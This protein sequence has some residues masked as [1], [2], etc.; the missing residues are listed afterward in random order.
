MEY[1]RNSNPNFYKENQTMSNCGSFAFNIEEWYSPDT[2]FIDDYG[3]IEEW[4]STNLQ[5]SDEWEVSDLFAHMLAEYILRDFSDVRY[6]ICADE[7]EPNEELIAFRTFVNE[8]EMW[9]FHFK[10]FRNGEWQEK[11]GSGPVKFCEEDEWQTGV[12]S[13]ISETLYF[14]KL[15][16]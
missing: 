5:Y 12:N 11:C 14:A 7:I 10:V 15:I 9:D 1:T 2:D 3:D 16:A 6:L 13:Y 8:D 4:I